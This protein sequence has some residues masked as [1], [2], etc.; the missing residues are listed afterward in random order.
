MGVITAKAG[1][2]VVIPC[3]FTTPDGFIPKRDDFDIIFHIN[4]YK[5]PSEFLGRVLLLDPDVS[6][7]N[8]SIMI[9]DLTTSDSGSYQ[10][11]VNGFYRGMSDGV[12]FSS[13]TILSVK[14]KI[15]LFHLN[16]PSLMIPPLT[17]GQ[18]ATLTC[19]APGLC[20]PSPPIITW[21]W[22]GKG[23]MEANITGNTTA[24]F[25]TENLTAVTQRHSSILTFNSSAKHHDTNLTC[26]VSYT[27]DITTEETV[28]LKVNCDITN[29]TGTP[30]ISG[31]STIKQDESLNLTCT[32]DSFPLS[33]IIWSKRG[34]NKT[35]NNE[36]KYGT[37][38]LVI[39]NVTKQH[40]GQ[41]FCYANHLNKT[42]EQDIN[43][44]VIS[45]YAI[46][47]GYYMNL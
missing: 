15:S 23:E 32:V 41:Y 43:I 12:T 19:T 34:L 11:R 16:R 27:S 47:L 9:N 25:K 28:T 14:A 30:T 42:L 40:S 31:K 26:K 7:G 46:F 21:M 1:L 24:S 3:S 36:T 38:T 20:S 13:K 18:Q 22:R 39:H 33:V 17:E 44:T 8:C 4:R 2:C 10:L 5:V 6:Q 35:L 45:K 29:G 37:S